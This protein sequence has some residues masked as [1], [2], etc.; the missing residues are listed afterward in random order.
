[1]HSRLRLLLFTLG[2]AI[3]LCSL[4]ALAYAFWP[5]DASQ[6]QATIEPTLFSPP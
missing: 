3:L 2:I 6:V 1:M 5:L 4:A